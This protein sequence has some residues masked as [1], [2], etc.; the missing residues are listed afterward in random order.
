MDKKN[1]AKRH[2]AIAMDGLDD[3]SKERNLKKEEGY[4][5]G[6]EL[7]LKIPKWLF[8]EK[9]KYLSVLVLKTSTYR[10]DKIGSIELLKMLNDFILENVDEF[11]K[12][13]IKIKFCGN[14][15]ALPGDLNET[16]LEIE[17]L[18]QTS[19][20]GELFL[21]INYDGKQELINAARKIFSQG[22]DADQI[23]YG[24]LKKYCYVNLPE[25]EKIVITAGKRSIGNFLILQGGE[26]QLIFTNKLWPELEKSDIV[27]FLT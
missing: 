4:K 16:Y 21:Y 7:F 6:I 24:M 25:P 11:N 19:E 1:N 14:L 9:Y 27:K 17:K 18:T 15:S 10:E 26:S 23:H 22:I 8:I 13:K 5:K 20:G 3:W 12:Q 2:I